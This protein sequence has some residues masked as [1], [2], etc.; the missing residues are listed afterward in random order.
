LSHDSTADINYSAPTRIQR[1]AIPVLLAGRDALV[2]AP[3]GSGK[4]LAYL[5]PL[6]NDLQVCVGRVLSASDCLASVQHGVT[7]NGT[8]R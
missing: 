4:T 5:A 2:Y 7:V 8:G 3:T 6:I 1:A